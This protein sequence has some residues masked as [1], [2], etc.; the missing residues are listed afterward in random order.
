MKTILPLENTVQEY[1]WGSRTALSELLGRANASGAPQAELWM[2]AHPKAPSRVVG[3]DGSAIPLDRLIQ[4]NPD[5]ILGPAASAKFG[6]RLPYLFKVLAA[7]QPLSVQAHPNRQQA[8]NGYRRENEQGIPLDAPHR[9]YK[10]NSHKPECI[11]ALTP[12]WGLCGF[13]KTAE[14]K[15]LMDPVA[16][17]GLNTP[18]EALE[19]FSGPE[20]LRAF[21]QEIMTLPQGEKEALT[22]EAARKAEKLSTSGPVYDWMVRLHQAYP[23]DAGMLSPAFLNLVCLQPGE[24]LYLPAGELHAYLD[25]TGIELMAN[26]DNVLRG[27]LTPKHV[28]VPELMKVLTFQKRKIDILEPV[29]ENGIERIYACPAEEFQLSV[30]RVADKASYASPENRSADI[31][32]CIDGSASAECR[33]NRQKMTKGLSVLIPAA[34]GP[35][36]IQGEATLYKAAVPL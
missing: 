18:L 25:G 24:A 14:I 11:C 34:A 26:S 12:F 21:F 4:E 15:S 17:S 1:P 28:D 32:L 29:P 13:R 2:G 7:G 6:G 22:K 10:D 36:T 31:L 19:K 5:A 23:G 27:G 3:T 8:E 33:H 35:Y 20:G 16:S 9:N 30:I